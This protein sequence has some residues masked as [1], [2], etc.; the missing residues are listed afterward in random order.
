MTYTIKIKETNSDLA[1]NL[2]F[3]LK[4]LSE[5]E[6]YNFLQIIEP[7]DVALSKEVK[8][9]LDFRYEHF[10]QHHEKYNDWED[11]KH[12]YLNR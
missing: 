5:T 7:D 1:K 4:S 3:Y 6:E 8:K 9:E 2:L 11:V 10:L 12:K